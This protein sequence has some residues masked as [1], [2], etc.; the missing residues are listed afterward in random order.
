MANSSYGLIGPTI[1]A[2]NTVQQVRMDKQGAQIMSNLHAPFYEQ[3]Y[4]GNVF[5]LSVATA[6]AITAFT[7]GAAGTPQIALWNPSGS[8]R[9]AVIISANYG[10]AVAASA[11]GTV[12]W[13]LYFGQTAAI[14]QATTTAP[15]SMVT[16]ATGGSVMTGF[17]NVALTSSTALSNVIP[18]GSYYWATAAGAALVTSAGEVELKGKLIIPP[19]AVVALGG[20]SA[21]T[22]ATWIG[23]LVWEEV[24]L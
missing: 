18:I 9:N 13:G 24:P 8:G 22:S 23:S 14:T 15:T 21:L 19:G 17:R 20:S 16:L 11:A 2:D 6:A 5:S 1:G 12:A 3:T 10:N 7:G 4:R